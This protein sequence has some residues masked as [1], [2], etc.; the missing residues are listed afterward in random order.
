MHFRGGQFLIAMVSYGEGANSHRNNPKFTSP[1]LNNPHMHTPDMLSYS[2]ST[3]GH[4]HATSMHRI[5]GNSLLVYRTET[6][7]THA[8]A[9]ARASACVGKCAGS[10]V[11][12]N[13]GT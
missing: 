7:H 8:R 11:Q 12:S 4:A 13:D 10:R 6:L 2:L 1:A 9:S 3:A 5:N